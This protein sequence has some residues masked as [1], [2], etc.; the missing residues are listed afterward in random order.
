[1]YAIKRFVTLIWIFTVQT[2]FAPIALVNNAIVN[3]GTVNVQLRKEKNMYRIELN[4]RIYTV[5]NEELNK[6]D[7]ATRKKVVFIL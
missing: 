5:T 7:R 4:G 1:M 6:M 2:V 3:I